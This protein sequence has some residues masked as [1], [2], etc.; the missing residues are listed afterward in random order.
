M[1][2]NINETLVNVVELKGRER[3][4]KFYPRNNTYSI[5]FQYLFIAA[6]SMN[7]IL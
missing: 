5:I 4:L 6:L 2:L 3:E 1:Q 7:R